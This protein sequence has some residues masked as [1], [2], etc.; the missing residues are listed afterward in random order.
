MGPL[1]TT[2]LAK[3]EIEIYKESKNKVFSNRK[4]LNNT[5]IIIDWDDTL[6]CTHFVTIKNSK[7]IDKEYII[8][9]N[10]G[11][12]VY[13]FLNKIKKYGTVFILTNSSK[14][15]VN[16]SSL[17]FLKIQFDVFKDIRVISARDKFSKNEKKKNF[18][19]NMQWNK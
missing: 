16:F 10:L 2:E 1:L 7:F 5:I 3:S 15:W 4:A 18:G 11:K 19:K 13:T 8:M 14:E 17:K 9:E 12:I 6:M